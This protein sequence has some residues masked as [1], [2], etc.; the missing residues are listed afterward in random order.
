MIQSL[1]TRRFPL[2]VNPSMNV[3]ATQIDPRSPEFQGS[4]TQLRAMVDD[5][6]RELARIA[7]GGGAKA[8]ERH[9]ARGK[10][11]PRDRKSTRLNSSH[12]SISY[13]VFC[14]K[15]KDIWC[16]EASSF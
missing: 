5:L 12:P 11:L 6:H 13:A 15:K 4:T 14:L 9:V 10:M 8:R 7:E 2:P 16:T 3:F 1:A